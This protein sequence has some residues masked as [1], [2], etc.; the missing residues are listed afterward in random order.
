MNTPAGLV[1]ASASIVENEVRDIK[2]KNVA[3]FVYLLDQ[4]VEVDRI[5]TVIFDIAFGGVFYA[6][7]DA[8]PLGCLLEKKN[9]CHTG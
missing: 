6:I 7:V 8:E 4:K 2:F 3:S 1:H 9:P 5:G